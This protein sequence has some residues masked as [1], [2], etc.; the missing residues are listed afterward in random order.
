MYEDAI[1]QIAKNIVR[2]R[3]LANDP[4]L[5]EFIRRTYAEIARAGED[6]LIHTADRLIT[7]RV[8]VLG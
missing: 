8:M 7:L 1:E 2:Y 5:S 3:E 6:I 4:S